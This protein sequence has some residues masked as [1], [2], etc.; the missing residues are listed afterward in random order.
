MGRPSPRAAWGRLW[1]RIRMTKVRWP[2][3]AGVRTRKGPLARAFP[4]RTIGGS[5]ADQRPGTRQQVREARS[6][7]AEAPLFC[8]EQAPEWLKTIGICQLPDSQLVAV[9][10]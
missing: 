4:E 6:S 5:A 8:A 10:V 3:P 7:A 9:A 2:S 1:C